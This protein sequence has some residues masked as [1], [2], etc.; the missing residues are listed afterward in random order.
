M[1]TEA[2]P[3]R[4]DGM[5]AEEEEE[6]KSCCQVPLSRVGARVSSQAV[7]TGAK[8]QEEVQ[9]PKIKRLVP[10][11]KAPLMWLMEGGGVVGGWSSLLR[12]MGTQLPAAEE[13][14]RRRER[15][16]CWRERRCR[17]AW[18][19]VFVCVVPVVRGCECVLRVLVCPEHEVRPWVG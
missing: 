18:V 3:N 11:R 9:P 6:G 4:A 13:E 2:A 17:M 5:E 1:T 19:S 8:Q 10:L 14:R 7:A 15:R 12:A 16:P